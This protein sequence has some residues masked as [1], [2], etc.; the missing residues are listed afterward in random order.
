MDHSCWALS[1]S[2]KVDLSEFWEFERHHHSLTSHLIKIFKKT[3]WYRRE[4]MILEIYNKY[5]RIWKSG[6][7]WKNE[8]KGLCIKIDTAWRPRVKIIQIHWWVNLVW[9]KIFQVRNQVLS[10]TW[11]SWQTKFFFNKSRN[12]EILWK[13]TEYISFKIVINAEN[14]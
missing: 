3:F 5:E 12:R 9:M 14:K 1:A 6:S 7:W 13:F 10:P 11:A 8:L 2:Y 4:L